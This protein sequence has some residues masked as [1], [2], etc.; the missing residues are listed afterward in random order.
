MAKD[1]VEAVKDAWENKPGRM[2]DYHRLMQR[3]LRRRW[4]ALADALD[5]LVKED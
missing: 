5:D 2:P 1:K 3:E 4:P